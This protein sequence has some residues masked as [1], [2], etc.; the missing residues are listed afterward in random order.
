MKLAR[1]LDRRAVRG[2]LQPAIAGAQHIGE[3]PHI[4]FLHSATVFGHGAEEHGDHA[5]TQAL[6]DCIGNMSSGEPPCPIAQLLEEDF[7]LTGHV[8]CATGPYQTAALSRPG[9]PSALSHQAIL[10][11]VQTLLKQDVR[12]LQDDRRIRSGTPEASSPFRR[13]I[14]SATGA[15]RT[16]PNS[17]ASRTPTSSRWRRRS[18]G[19]WYTR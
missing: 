6:T 4:K 5:F 1:I 7:V 15:N 11:R 9:T 16:F 8:P 12:R 18:A 2:R 17:Q 3:N 10:G 19:S 13:V 14:R